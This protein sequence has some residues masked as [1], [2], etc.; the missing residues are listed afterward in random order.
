M[1]SVKLFGRRLRATVLALSLAA[2]TGAAVVGTTASAGAASNCS[3]GYVALTFDDGP[4]ASTTTLLLGVLK[5]AGV[6]ATLFNIGQNVAANPTLVAAE[7]AAGMWIGNHTYTHADLNSLSQAAIQSELTSTQQAIVAAGGTAPTI[8]RPPYGNHNATVD[9]VV[10]GLGLKLVTWDVDTQDWNGV[11]T[12]SIVGTA[13]TVAGGGLIL[14]H[15]GFQ[16]TRD[17]IPQIV[18][19]LTA[20][21]LCAGMISPSTG[22]AVAPDG[23]TP[24]TSVPTTPPPT[25]ST[26][27]TSPPATSTPT[28]PAPGGCTAAYSQTGAW[29]GGFQGQVTVTAGSSAIG[30]WTVS[31]VLGNGQ[32]VSSL[33]S[34][35]A[36][37][38][39]GT[40]TV[41][42]AAWNGS[43]AAG[44]ATTFGFVATASGAV[45]APTV[46]CTT[47]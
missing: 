38:T 42:N 36:T 2:G 15:D 8:F 37:G 35:T 24:T 28:T 6:R 16:T 33:W 30:S 25:T 46:T 43:L 45:T 20:R 5:T 7:Q 29:P 39:S 13:S 19:N 40:V 4:N 3:N 26:P 47:P 12:A 22:R 27:T 34:G 32:T 23:S 17:A 31:M 44:A 9:A 10:A 11:S 41:R 21:S 14:M 1:S 18:A